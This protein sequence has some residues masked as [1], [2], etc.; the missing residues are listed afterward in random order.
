MRPSTRCTLDVTAYEATGYSLV[1]D[2]GRQVGR[3]LGCR[4]DA[5]YEAGAHG[6]VLFVSPDTI[7]VGLLQILLV[8]DG[9]IAEQLRLGSG[10]E[11][12]L[13]TEFNSPDAGTITFRFPFDALRR[14]HVAPRSSLFGL[15]RRVLHLDP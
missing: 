5:Q 10:S 9:T 6:I 12:G 13:A 1:L 15:R 8:R 11:Q 2:D 7:F 3:V 4:I 14:L